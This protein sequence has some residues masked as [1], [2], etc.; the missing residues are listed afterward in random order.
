VSRAGGLDLVAVGHV[1]L[2]ETPQG[3]RPG[4][5]AYYASITAHRLG[6]R[7][8]L[9]TSCGADF[10]RAALPAD[11]DITVVPAARTTRYVLASVEGGR[12]LRLLERAERIGVAGLPGPWRRAP[13]VLLCPVASEVDPGLAAAFPDGAV[14]VLPQGWMRRWGPQGEVSPAGWEHAA[15]VLAH[16]QVVVLSDEDAAESLGEVVEWF[17]RVPLGAIT[18]AAAGAT[19]YVNGEPYHVAPD[20]VSAVDDTGAGDVFATTLLVDYQ[21]GG[22]PWSAAAAAAC[23]AAA[24]VTGEGAAAIPGRAELDA[25]L[26]AHLRRH[27]R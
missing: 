15:A 14:G 22:D 3:T 6:L 12:R 21:R 8:G 26:A 13:L 5:A 2:D 16:A 19:L 4:G 1:T 18:R 23:A 27:V 20:P 25:R 10:P 9:L 17:Q 24:S 11:L 7:V